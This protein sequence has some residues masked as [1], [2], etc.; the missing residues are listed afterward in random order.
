MISKFMN[1]LNLLFVL[2]DLT[3]TFFTGNNLLRK[4]PVNVINND[5][6]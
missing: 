4:R 5:D 1:V 6:E 2:E 3:C